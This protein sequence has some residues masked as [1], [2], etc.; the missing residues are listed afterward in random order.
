[1]YPLIIIIVPTYNNVQRLNKC[2]EHIYNNTYDNSKV[3]IVDDQCTD[4]TAEYINQKYPEAIVLRTPKELFWSGSL[5]FG[6]KKATELGASYIRAWNDDAYM[7]SDFLINQ[8][9]L[10]QKYPNAILA[11]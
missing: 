10:S 11:P 7:A 9:K 4:G 2:L 3:I 6:F 8:Y 5:N 1:M